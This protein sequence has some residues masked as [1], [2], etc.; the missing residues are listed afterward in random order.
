VRRHKWLSGIL[1]FDVT[2]LLIAHVVGFAHC[3]RPP[4]G[5]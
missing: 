5:A 4:S 1:A 3:A 2:L